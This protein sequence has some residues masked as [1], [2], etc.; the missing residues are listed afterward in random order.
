MRATMKVNG[1]PVTLDDAK[2]FCDFFSNW[3]GEDLSVSFED[4]LIVLKSDGVE[5]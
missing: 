3:Y 2:E 1:H 5:E 4:G